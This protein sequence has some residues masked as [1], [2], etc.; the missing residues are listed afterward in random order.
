MMKVKV[1]QDFPLRYAGILYQPGAEFDAADKHAAAM[2][3]QKRVAVLKAAPMPAERKA[4]IKAAIIELQK[5]T[6]DKVPS[7]DKI[8]AK[9]GFA[10]KAEERDALIAEMN[11]EQGE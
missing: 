3:A 11:D 4:A 2:A 7:V 6:P 1:I 5:E 9:S 8:K 10:V